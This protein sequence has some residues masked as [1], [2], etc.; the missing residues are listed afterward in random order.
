MKISNE[1]AKNN[2]GIEI[3]EI[4][5][6]KGGILYRY[7]IK[8]PSVIADGDGTIKIEFKI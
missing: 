3:K 4:I 6:E 5:Y 8:N 2:F 1:H 7:D